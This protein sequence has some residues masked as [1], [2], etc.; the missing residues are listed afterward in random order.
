MMTNVLSL[1]FSRKMIP[2][3]VLEEGS[4]EKDVIMYIN[5]GVPQMVGGMC[6]FIYVISSYSCP[7]VVVTLFGICVHL[8]LW[9]KDRHIPIIYFR[10]K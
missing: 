1:L 6:W 7:V 2:L 10:R 8:L 4:Y 5:L 9:M 3:A